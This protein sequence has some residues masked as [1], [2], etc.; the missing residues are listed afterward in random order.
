MKK[1]VI[2]LLLLMLIGALSFFG[3][4]WWS[5][6]HDPNIDGIVNGYS[7]LCGGSLKKSDFT[8]VNN[9]I[10]ETIS[11]VIG[12]LKDPSFTF[13]DA[14]NQLTSFVKIDKEKRIQI[15]IVLTNVEASTIT[16]LETKY[17]TK[18]GTVNSR[19]NVV[20]AWVH[21]SYIEPLADENF[22]KKIETLDYGRTH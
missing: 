20:T 12:F 3:Y 7:P 14:D 9:K 11:C 10:D 19:L 22:V 21:Y 6:K 13:E 2:F 5:T 8:P 18:A 15:R 1:L 16:E 17:K 4:T